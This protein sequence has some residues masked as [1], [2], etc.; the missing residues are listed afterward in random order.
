MIQQI[1][2]W[3]TLPPYPQRTFYVR[4]RVDAC[5]AV[6]IAVG[7]ALCADTWPFRL[8]FLY[9]GYALFDLGRT[10]TLNARYYNEACRRQ[11]ARQIME[12]MVGSLDEPEAANDN[13]VLGS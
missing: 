1:R 2:A 3:L 13:D 6:G 5:L 12:S 9:A 10:Y 7:L 4:M 11:K 8:V